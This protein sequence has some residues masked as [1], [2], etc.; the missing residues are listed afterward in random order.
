MHP[1]QEGP[2]RHTC[3]HEQTST[4]WLKVG[5]TQNRRSIKGIK[6]SSMTHLGIWGRK[7]TFSNTQMFAVC[8]S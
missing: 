4:H 7:T 2:G 5:S 8:R 3:V 6:V 1:K